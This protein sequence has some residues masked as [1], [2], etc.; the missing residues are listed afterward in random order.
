MQTRVL[1]AHAHVD[2]IVLNVVAND[3]EGLWKPTYIKT[4]ALTNGVELRPLMCAHLGAILRVKVVWFGQFLEV[5]DGWIGICGWG[6]VAFEYL[7][8][9]VYLKDLTLFGFEL[10][11][12]EGG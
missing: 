3:K 8:L 2:L 10:L 9:G 5:L 6:P 12:Q 4:L 7:G 1:F 11:L